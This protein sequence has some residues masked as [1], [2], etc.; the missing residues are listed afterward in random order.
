MA[1]SKIVP[2]S[3]T[4]EL[5][6]AASAPLGVLFLNFCTI[7]DMHAG[8]FTRFG[9]LD[10]VCEPGLRWRPLG[11]ERHEVF[12]GVQTHHFKAMHVTEARGSPIHVSAV[13]SFVVTDPVAFVFG[14]RGTTK[15][16]LD[17]MEAYIRDACRM[18][19]MISDTEVNM[20]QN[21]KEIMETVLTPA[22]TSHL[23]DN[24]GVSVSEL[25]LTQTEYAPEIAQAMLVKQQVHATVEARTLLVHGITPVVRDVVDTL[26]SEM[27]PGQ[28]AKFVT[29]LTI[30]LVGHVPIAPVQTVLE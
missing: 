18:Y 14:A 25:K 7:P 28:K 6:K 12:K 5:L 17:L 16:V 3:L 9:K 19:P 8:V 23:L 15:P 27:D 1:I 10:R 30:P 24:F 2:L 22:H 29:G 11:G 20:Q 21:G 26:G 4:E 13:M